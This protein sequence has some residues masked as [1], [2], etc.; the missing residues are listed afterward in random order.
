MS[1]PI[2]CCTSTKDSTCSTTADSEDAASVTDF[3]NTWNDSSTTHLE[4]DSDGGS[5]SRTAEQQTINYNPFSIGSILETPRVPRG[6]RP[7][8]KYPRLQ[9]CKSYMAAAGT[10]LFG[11]CAGSLQPLQPV[12]QPVGFQVERLPSPPCHSDN[13]MNS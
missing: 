9:A 13:S 4:L 8:S 11:L 7:N 6:R 1:S 3:N 12:T 5:N 2:Q 10:S